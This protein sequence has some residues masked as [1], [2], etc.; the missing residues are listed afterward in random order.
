M[1]LL[2]AVPAPNF[3]HHFDA[4]F[5]SIFFLSPLHLSVNIDKRVRGII[6]RHSSFEDASAVANA[7]TRVSCSELP[8]TNS[9]PASTRAT[10]SQLRHQGHR[11]AS[12]TRIRTK[13]PLPRP[14][15]SHSPPAHHYKPSDHRR[16][17]IAIHRP[18][19]DAVSLQ[20]VTCYKRSASS[21]IVGAW[22]LSPGPR[23]LL[24][25]TPPTLSTH[26]PPL[27]LHLSPSRVALPD[28]LTVSSCSNRTAV[29]CSP[30]ASIS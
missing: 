6:Q 28:T 9:N 22:S 13:H 20:L 16:P 19:I 8:S 17:G 3:A 10:T 12:P 4:L 29:A 30:I 5:S 14:F 21:S 11:R 7:V 15:L 18:V 24:P 25:T 1:H 27:S 23:E 2:Q 26:Q